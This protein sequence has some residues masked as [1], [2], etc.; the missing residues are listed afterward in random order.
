MIKLGSP[1]SIVDERVF[2]RNS[3]RF[4]EA[5]ESNGSVTALVASASVH[6]FREATL[7][8]SRCHTGSVHVV[9]NM[10]LQPTT[11]G[12]PAA[13][14]HHS[15]A[16]V[17]RTTASRG[18]EA[19]DAQTPPPSNHH[20]LDYLDGLRGVAACM[21]VTYH[22]M[23]MFL[24]SYVM[25]LSWPEQREGAPLSYNGQYRLPSA[26]QRTFLFFF[27]DGRMA[28]AIFFVLSGRVLVAR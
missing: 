18:S 26:I 19:L 15:S 10:E 21:V 28:V 1:Y 6:T 11:V 16:A 12:A 27:M 4:H 5:K 7:M 25:A 23:L 17:P 3:T 13:T 2:E 9:V 24:P 22:I 14:P 8:H 20:K